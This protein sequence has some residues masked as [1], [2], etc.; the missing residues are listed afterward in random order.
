MKVISDVPVSRN[1]Y[2]TVSIFSKI[3][4]NAADLSTMRV[5]YTGDVSL[6]LL[7]TFNRQPKL[8]H[9]IFLKLVLAYPKCGLPFQCC[10]YYL[11]C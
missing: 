2:K 11:R 7:V 1:L 8:T 9:M 5:Q 4:I 3:H 6:N 10:Q